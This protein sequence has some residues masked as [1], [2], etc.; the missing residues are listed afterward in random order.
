MVTLGMKKTPAEYKKLATAKAAVDGEPSPAPGAQVA[1]P[2]PALLSP[3]EEPVPTGDNAMPEPQS[4]VAAD[5]A[6]NVAS[7]SSSASSSSSRPTATTPVP[8]P[9]L[10]RFCPRCDYDADPR[11]SNYGVIEML[12]THLDEAQ[13]AIEALTLRHKLLVDLFRWYRDEF[14]QA[15][16]RALLNAEEEAEEPG[17]ESIELPENLH[18]IARESIA[19]LRR[20]YLATKSQRDV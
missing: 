10:T 2:A 12:Q 6:S 9:I 7:R 4:A 19:D 13:D 17:F 1:A 14:N 5:Q 15:T 11:V 18:A 20:R 16:G 8:V 3:P